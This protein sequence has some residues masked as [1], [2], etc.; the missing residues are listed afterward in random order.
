MLSPCWHTCAV[1]L[2]MCSVLFS[3]TLHMSVC[4]C[5]RLMLVLR[6]LNGKPLVMLFRFIV[7]TLGEGNAQV[8]FHA[9]AKQIVLGVG[10]FLESK[11]VKGA[12]VRD[13]MGNCFDCVA[14]TTSPLVAVAPIYNPKNCYA[15]TLELVRY[16]D[17]SVAEHEKAKVFSMCGPDGTT[18]G[19]DL[20]MMH[21][22]FMN[23]HTKRVSVC[24][25]QVKYVSRALVWTRG[26]NWR[27]CA[28]EALEQGGCDF[29]ASLGWIWW[30]AWLGNSIL[31]VSFRVGFSLH[32]AADIHQNKTRP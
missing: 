7:C 15:T 30:L 8:P 28:L 10:S 20:A 11:L 3:C 24:T 2:H 6:E 27:W 14:D 26:T 31:R 17:A 18:I 32:S 1:L 9:L 16:M 12:V 29:I 21:A 22:A 25:P 5:V 19:V 13:W 4:V 23:C